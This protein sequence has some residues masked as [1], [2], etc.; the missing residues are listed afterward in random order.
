MNDFMEARRKLLEEL[1]AKAEEASA[2][3][4]SGQGPTAIPVEEPDPPTEPEP[5]EYPPPDSNSDDSTEVLSTR[6]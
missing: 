1:G 4:P 5:L 6:A 2:D 3:A